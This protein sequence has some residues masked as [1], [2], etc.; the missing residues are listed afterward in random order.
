[1]DPDLAGR[2]RD[3]RPRSAN[4]GLVQ[5]RSLLCLLATLLLCWSLTGDAGA[6][7]APTGLLSGVVVDRTGSLSSGGG[8][9]AHPG[10]HRS[11]AQHDGPGRAV[12]LRRRAS[13]K[14]RAGRADAGLRA[15]AADRAGGGGRAGDAPVTL[16]LAPQADAVT[17]TPMRGTC[18]GSRTRRSRRP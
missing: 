12:P 15:G 11:R 10:R 5:G 6:A 2:G 17:V 13:G 9:A 8:G 14:L 3:S 4:G 18:A 16:D 1:M 7:P